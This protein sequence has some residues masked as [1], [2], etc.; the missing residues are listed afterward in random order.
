MAEF[1]SSGLNKSAFCRSR[2]LTWGTLNRHLALQQRSE[3]GARAASPLVA[4]ELT[5]KEAA[6]ENESSSRLAVA[7]LGGRRIEVQCG[8]DDHTLQR[9][10]NLLERM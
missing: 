7:L 2:G 8:F 6:S 1:G 9:L 3:R 4:V 10:V 5:G